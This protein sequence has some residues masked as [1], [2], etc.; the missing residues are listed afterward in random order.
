MP[1]GRLG[2]GKNILTISFQHCMRACC[3]RLLHEPSLWGGMEHGLLRCAIF[4]DRLLTERRWPKM[5]DIESGISSPGGING[6]L[7][8]QQVSH[9]IH[10]IEAI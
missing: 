7:M 10:Y 5:T 4:P 8:W 1:T 2:V 9:L 6:L 3:H